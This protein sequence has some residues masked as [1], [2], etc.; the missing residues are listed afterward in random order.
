MFEYITIVAFTFFNGILLRLIL[1]GAFNYVFNSMAMAK[2]LPLIGIPMSISM[3]L[4]GHTLGVSLILGLFA[5]DYAPVVKFIANKISP[6]E[7]KKT[8]KGKASV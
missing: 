4:S 2:P 8:Q 3:I 1:A 7:T 5:M 6:R